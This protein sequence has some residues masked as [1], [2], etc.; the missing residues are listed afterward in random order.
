VLA[1]GWCEA[2]QASKGGRDLGRSRAARSRGD[3]GRR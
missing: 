2:V 1:P 3:R